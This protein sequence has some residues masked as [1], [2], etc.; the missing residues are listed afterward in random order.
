MVSELIDLV[1]S[2]SALMR[3]E[4][5]L[6]QSRFGGIQEIAGAK[7]RLVA[8]LDTKS[9]ELGRH[10]ADWLEKLEGPQKDELVEALRELKEASVPNA[11]ALSRQIDLSVE[12]LA[13]VT[14]EAKRLT[15]T[16]H[17]VYGA[18]GGLSRMDLPTP[19]SHNSHY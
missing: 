19:I 9:A 6:L 11:E 14:A 16:R 8:C 5:Q 2:L 3:E 17:A 13:A 12:M 4:T 18:A 15:G 10:D 1:K 7:A